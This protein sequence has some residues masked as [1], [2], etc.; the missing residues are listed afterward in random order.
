M[1]DRYQPAEISTRLRAVAERSDLRIEARL[2]SKV[3]R[4]SAA[5]MARLRKVAELRRLGLRLA[6][7]GANPRL[8]LD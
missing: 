3:P 8:R 5:T 1:S 4:E 7:A 2:L 6:R